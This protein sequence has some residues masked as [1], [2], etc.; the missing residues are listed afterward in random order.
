MKN[1]KKLGGLGQVLLV[2][3]VVVATLASITMIFPF[4]AV[5]SG[6]PDVTFCH[7]TGSEKNPYNQITTDAA[8]AYNGHWK[9]HDDDVMPVFEYNGFSYGPRGALDILANGC[10]IPVPPTETP[11]PPT[12]TPIPP[13]ATPIPP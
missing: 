13:T 7:A 11:I 8:G 1:H 6:D 5:A 9:K 12:E 2:A 3:L 10:E 4:I